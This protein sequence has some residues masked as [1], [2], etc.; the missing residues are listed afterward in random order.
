MG[1]KLRA[2]ER[3][4]TGMTW[5]GP[6]LDN[7]LH[8]DLEQGS[9]TEGVQ[10]FVNAGGT[11]LLI[12]NKPSWWYG[13][14]VEAPA[15]FDVGYAATVSMVSQANEILPGRAWP[16]LGVHP[17]LISR[18]VDD[19]G[20]TP[21]EAE[22]LMKGGIDRAAERV[23]AGEALAIKSG[24]PH[25]P[26][27][28]DVWSASN[29]VMRHAFARAAEI[30][31]AVQLHTEATSAFETVAEWAREAGLDPAR[32]VKHYADGPVEGVTPSVIARKEALQ[33]ALQANTPFL[34][35]TDFLDDPE[36]PGAVL[37][38]KTVPRRVH[39]LAEAG[40]TAALERAHVDT[41]RQVY[42]IATRETMAD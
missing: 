3:A 35:E 9:G 1:P 15:D 29:A 13:Q 2:P 8:L 31:C 24:R 38:P 32:V 19:R 41:P 34:M 25:Y 12:V 10:T 39:W 14:E 16:V 27:S 36:R 42:G 37:G 21:K 6:V 22:E 40:E 20:Y 17:A 33:H 4:Q 28:E 5:T 7:H 18:L 11:H 30:D 23:E 26:V